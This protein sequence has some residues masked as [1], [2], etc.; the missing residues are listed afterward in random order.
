MIP[1]DKEFELISY[2]LESPIK[3]LFSVELASEIINNKIEIYAKVDLFLI[4]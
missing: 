2:R 3:A 1:P 4:G